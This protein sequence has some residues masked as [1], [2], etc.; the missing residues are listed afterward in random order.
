MLQLE[1]LGKQHETHGFDCGVESLN[2][3]LCSQAWP[4]QRAE[5]S[6]TYVISEGVRVVGYVS[7]AAGSLSADGVTER[8]RRGQ[9]TQ[10]VPAM[11]I[12]RLAVDRA[13]QGRGLGGGL[14]VVALG[15]CIAAADIIGARAVV[16]DARSVG[17]A[18][19]YARHGFEPS[20]QDPLQ[21]MMLMKDIRRTLGEQA[22]S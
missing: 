8:V 15:K 12:G 21:L 4:D 13:W 20:P 1:P 18:P 17:I 14:L 2:T 16:V 10:R 22:L 9:G 3:Y 6:R 5:K 11:V 19:F 7:L